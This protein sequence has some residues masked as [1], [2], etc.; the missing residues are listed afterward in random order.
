M[1]R[2][3][4]EMRKIEEEG[5][6][7]LPANKVLGFV[8]QKV[9]EVGLGRDFNGG[10]GRELEMPSARNDGLVKTPPTRKILSLFT[11]MPLAEHGRLISRRF[12]RLGNRGPVEGKLSHVVDRA[13]RAGTPVE[14]INPAHGVNP[15]AGTILAG[16]ERGAGRLAVLGVMMIGETHSLRGE[17][18]NVRGLVVAAPVTGQ[19]GIAKVVRKDENDVRFLRTE[20]GE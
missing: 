16:H 4:P 18:V 17:A 12:E 8:G 7:L 13:K 9:C 3:D 20:R 10:N 2:M 5:S 1:G 14:P 11:E 6:V 19:V 15:G